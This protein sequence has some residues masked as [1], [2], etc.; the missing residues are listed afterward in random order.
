MG[1]TWR[2]INDDRWE[3]G[4]DDEIGAARLVA[5]MQWGRGTWE[6]VFPDDPEAACAAYRG[7]LMSMFKAERLV[8]ARKAAAR[9]T[10]R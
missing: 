5:V 9:G 2:R 4:D 10:H 7:L 8:L 1:M 6:I 3:Y